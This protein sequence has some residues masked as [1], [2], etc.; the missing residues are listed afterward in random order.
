MCSVYMLWCCCCC[1]FVWRRKEV[2]DGK[3][4]ERKCRSG[5]CVVGG[6]VRVTSIKITDQIPIELK[7]TRTKEGH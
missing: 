7:Q 4:G 1:V 5:V 3:G 2:D 6:G